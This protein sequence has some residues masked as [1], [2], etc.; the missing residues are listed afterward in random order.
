MANANQRLGRD[1]RVGSHL[2]P[3]HQGMDENSPTWTW[4]AAAA[5]AKD[6]VDRLRASNDS[7]E[8]DPVS[9][10]AIRGEIRALKRLLNEPNAIVQRQLAKSQAQPDTW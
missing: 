9:T 1:T 4:A 10:A 2:H 5:W 6:E 8:H 7:V 3:L